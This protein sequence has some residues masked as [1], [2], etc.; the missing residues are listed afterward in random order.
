MVAAVAVVMIVD[1]VVVMVAVVVV[2]VIMQIGGGSRAVAGLHRTP[3]V[4]AG[5][6]FL[7]LIALRK[8]RN[9]PTIW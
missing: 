7:L 1:V 5:H 6:I 2:A 3:H 9:R 8:H 4:E